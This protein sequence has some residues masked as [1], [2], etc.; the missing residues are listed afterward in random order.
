MQLRLKKWIGML[1][2]QCFVY[3]KLKTLKYYNYDIRKNKQ[4]ICKI[5]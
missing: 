1:F 2:E 5:F 3:K 4:P